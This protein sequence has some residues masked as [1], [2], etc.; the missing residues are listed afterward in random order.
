[1]TCN[2]AVFGGTPIRKEKL[3]YGKQTVEEDDVSAVADA[4]RS[5]F[6]T[7]G[8]RI[9]EFEK[10]LSSAVGAEYGVAVSSGTAALHAAVFAA[11]N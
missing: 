7:T 8:P 2:L 1:M 10:A 6:L 9:A 3:Y 5:S 4:V 11:N